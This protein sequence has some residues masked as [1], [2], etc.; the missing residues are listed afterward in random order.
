MSTTNIFLAVFILLL[1]GL[2]GYWYVSSNQITQVESAENQVATNE[3]YSIPSAAVAQAPVPQPSATTPPTQAPAPA[4]SERP[5]TS[6]TIRT[7]MGDIEIIFNPETPNTVANF[8]KL[9]KSGFYDGT[10]FH[11][12]IKGFMSQG[13][14]PFSRDDSKVDMWGRGG[15]G[16]TF[17]DEITASNSNDTLT[18]SMANAGPNTNGS[19]FFINAA[20]NH[21]LDSKHT[22]FA[23][24]TKGQDVATAINSVETGQ[25]D[26]PLKPVVITSISL[27]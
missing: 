1:L 16:Y 17:A 11:R 8:L 19:Q 24:V 10:K 9:A 12:V 5:I 13:G 4:A 14:D 3:Q 23:R 20:P 15:P 6:A 22:V 25:A 18:V 26:R 7:N 2:G 27:K 21:S